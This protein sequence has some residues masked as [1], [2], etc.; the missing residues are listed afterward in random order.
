MALTQ[1][2]LKDVC[3][4]WGGDQQCRY[5]DEDMDDKGN[6]VYVCKKKSP[7]AKIIDIELADWLKDVK[8]KGQDPRKQG[9]PLGDGCSGYL[10]LTTKQQGYDV[11]GKKP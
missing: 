1:K 3:Y 9:V 10:K 6:I 7:D 11:D 8:K 5:L 2:H 4:I